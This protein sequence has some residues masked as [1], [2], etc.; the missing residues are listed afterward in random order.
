MRVIAGLVAVGVL[1]A[2]SGANAATIQSPTP[3]LT[4]GVLAMS[5]ETT[6]SGTSGTGLN[7]MLPTPGTFHYG[8]S[9]SGSSG[10]GSIG[11]TAA[12]PGYGFGFYDTFVFTVSSST[13][14]SITSTIDLGNFLKISGLQER[15][16]AASP[17]DPTPILGVPAAASNGSGLYFEAWSQPVIVGGS[18]L[19]TIAVLSQTNALP[20]G[21]YVLEVRGT[22]TGGAGGSY[23][24]TLNVNPVPLPAALPLLFSGLGLIGFAGRRR[25]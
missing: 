4:T 8:Q 2:V 10:S 21:T 16:Y 1:I 13:A 23:A 9:F 3:I 19:G 11:A 24:G 12:D 20:T 7:E 14:S 22:V 18:S 15:L 17:T 25:R 6:T 5:A